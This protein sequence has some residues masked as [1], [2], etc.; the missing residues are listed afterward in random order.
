MRGDYDMA[1]V[2]SD[3]LD[4]IIARGDIKGQDVRIIWESAMFPTAS[5]SIAH[6]LKPELATAIKTCMLG[7]RMPPE[8]SRELNGV[9]RFVPITYRE[10]W[11]PIREVAEKSGTPYNKAAYETRAK[12]EA[13]AAAKKAAAEPSPRQPATGAGTAAQKP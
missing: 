3:I 5:F 12:A 10:T 1:P 8:M 13:E 2:A 9:D 7:F 11:K 4:R 6:D